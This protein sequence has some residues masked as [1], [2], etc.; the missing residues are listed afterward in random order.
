MS[1]WH[2]NLQDWHV[3]VFESSQREG[4]Y[5]GDWLYFSTPLNLNL[6]VTFFA[7]EDIGKQDA[8]HI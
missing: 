6:T 2:V 7:R 8:A 3:H 4:L 1:T 5:I